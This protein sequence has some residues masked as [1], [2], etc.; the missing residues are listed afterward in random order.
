MKQS[1]KIFNFRGT[2]V[3]FNIW[4]LL[5]FFWVKPELAVCIFIAVL[6][7]ELGHAY[8]AKKFEYDVESVEVNFFGGFAKMDL[9][10]IHPKDLVKIT[11]AGPWVNCMLGS[12]SVLFSGLIYSHSLI[13]QFALVNFI[14]FLFNMIPIYP[15]DGGRILRTMMIIK[16][17]NE[18]RSIKIS[19]TIS[20]ILS[21]GLLVF[22]IFNFSLLMI[23]ISLIFIFMSLKDLRY[24]K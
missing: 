9:E 20:L 4:F 23:F 22:Y 13:Y 12:L 8:L 7:H 2:P 3:Y 14:I 1:F 16:T 10:K 6:L 21:L 24:I 11:A 18:E 19:S 15:L 5:L 17:Q